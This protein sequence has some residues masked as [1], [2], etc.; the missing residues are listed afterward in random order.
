MRIVKMRFSWLLRSKPQAEWRWT[1]K[2]HCSVPVAATLQRNLST[3]HAV[4]DDEIGEG[5]A[6]PERPPGKA[7][8]QSVWSR[9][10][11]VDSDVVSGTGRG[12][13]QA[14]I[15]SDGRS[16]EHHREI[17]AGAGERLEVGSF[18]AELNHAQQSEQNRN[19]NQKGNWIRPV[20]CQRIGA[21]NH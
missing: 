10:G 21:G 16:D 12:W 15:E 11:L 9:E 18:A 2:E 20:V 14:R 8:P 1:D 7:H 17:N 5:Q 3:E 13:Q 19:G 4:H 6:H